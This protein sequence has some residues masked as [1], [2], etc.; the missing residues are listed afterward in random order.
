VVSVAAA[1]FVGLLALAGT[2]NRSVAESAPPAAP[3][4]AD[5]RVDPAS[6]PAVEIDDDVAGLSAAL[7]TPEGARDLAAALAFN[8]NVEAQALQTRDPSLLIAVDHGQRLEDMRAAIDGAAGADIVVP[9]YEFDTLHLSIVFP[10]GFQS[11]ANAGLRATG[12]LTL[13]TYSPD[14]RAA[15]TT[16]QPFDTVFSLR[17]VT[18]ER[19]L[20]TDTPSS[21]TADSAH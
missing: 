9:S 3:V 8:L 20:T 1:A 2:P 4:D 21:A 13:T 6:L 10:G 11:G 5:L 16:T 18:S 19:W 17:N 15:G 12:T 14:G 7:A